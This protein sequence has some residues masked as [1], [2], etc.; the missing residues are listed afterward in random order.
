LD[1]YE[2]IV[3]GSGPAGSQAARLC[4]DHGME[5]LL[6]ERAS[7]PRSK[8]CAGG[9][10]ERSLNQLEGGIPSRLIERELN[11]FT[12]VNGK[13][14]TTYD[15]KRRIGVTVR[16]EELDA[17]LARQAEEDGATLLEDTAVKSA[18][19]LP[20]GVEVDTNRGK[21]HGRFLVLAEGA[22]GSLANGLL[23]PREKGA[24]AVGLAMECEVES[25]TGNSLIIHLFGNSRSRG[26]HAF[27][28]NGAAFPLDGA[29]TA[30]VVSNRSS[31][32][33]LLSALDIMAL[34]IDK[35]FGVKNRKDICAHPIPLAPRKKLC[36]KRV[37]AVGDA[38]GLV[39]PFSGEGLTYAFKSARIAF[40]V[41]DKA[42]GGPETLMSYQAMCNG[43]IIF[44]MKAARL[45]SPALHW[46]TGLTDMKTLMRAFSEEDELLERIATAATGE[47]DWRPVLNKVITRFPRLFFS[48]L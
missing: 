34:E 36:S 8:C 1:R 47:D 30:S 10:L 15:L 40:E 14:R 13:E 20:D 35:D 19:Q 39:S 9:M 44:H 33:Q 5:V 45:L 37:L 27:P 2:V 32:D 6:L 42:M 16:R 24:V 26:P 21:F 25:P 23:G 12:L 22:K 3:V 48:S 28:L 41:I 43:E 7:H 29:I 4:A 11:S 46:F 31:K 18:E 17:H 38:A